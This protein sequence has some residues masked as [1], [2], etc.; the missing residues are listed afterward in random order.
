[1]AEIRGQPV[2]GHH[3]PSPL[4]SFSSNEGFESSVVTAETGGRAWAVPKDWLPSN[5]GL[6]I[7]PTI[8]WLKSA[9]RVG[10]KDI[11]HVSFQGKTTDLSFKLGV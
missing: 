3:E 4:A 1:M 2:F 5:F 8:T 9:Q 10:K 7:I 11:Y 6:A